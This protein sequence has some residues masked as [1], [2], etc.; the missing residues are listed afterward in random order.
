M[1]SPLTVIDMEVKMEAWLLAQRAYI[2]SIEAEIQGMIAQNQYRIRRDEA[3]AY[4]DA[5]FQ[6][7]AKELQSIAN[8][9]LQN[10]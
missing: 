8:Y 7:K 2:A 6:A 3:I 9:I 4:D 5:A 1:G 10:R